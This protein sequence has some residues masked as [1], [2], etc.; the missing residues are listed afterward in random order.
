MNMM[1]D[2]QI[3]EQQDNNTCLLSKSLRFYFILCF[4]LSNPGKRQYEMIYSSLPAP[5]LCK[6]LEFPIS[7]LQMS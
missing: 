4:C 1:L 5:G 6:S 2:F 7:D 3:P